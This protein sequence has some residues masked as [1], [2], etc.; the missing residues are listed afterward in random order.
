MI[1]KATVIDAHD[2]ARIHVNTWQEAYR[3]IVP[4]SHLDSLSIEK[5][6]DNWNRILRQSPAGTIVVTDAE[7][8]VIRWASFGPSRDDDGAGVGELYAIYLQPDSWGNGYGRQ[9]MDSAEASLSSKGFAITLWVLGENVRTDDST[10]SLDITL[11][12]MKNRL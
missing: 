7:L 5:R 9:L 11:T 12:R 1:R 3:G 6:Q 8:A 2:I 10:K 4:Q